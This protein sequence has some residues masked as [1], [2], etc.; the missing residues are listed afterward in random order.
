MPKFL[1]FPGSPF[2]VRLMRF[3]AVLRELS[4]KRFLVSGWV[5]P[6]FGK[7]GSNIH[8]AGK[9][10]LGGNGWKAT[11]RIALQNQLLCKGWCRSRRRRQGNALS[12]QWECVKDQQCGGRKRY[13]PSIQI[14][15]KEPCAARILLPTASVYALFSGKQG[16]N[17][18]RSGTE[19]SLSV[20][21]SKVSG[22][23]ASG[24]AE[25]PGKFRSANPED[26]A[27]RP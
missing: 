18:K 22:A 25:G 12:L 8:H 5:L 26:G 6:S 27:S 9:T 2:L 23:A 13:A 11:T 7:Q 21:A 17:A 20:S 19:T 4:E 10:R 15:G 1:H 14:K 16:I 24:R 3:G